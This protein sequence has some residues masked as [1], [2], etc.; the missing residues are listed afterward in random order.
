MLN[1][2]FMTYFTRHSTTTNS[3]HDYA[4]VQ[5][6]KAGY[7]GFRT[8]LMSTMTATSTS[9]VAPDESTASTVQST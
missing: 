7:K 5:L 2:S 8:A 6:T 9:S 3:V 1:K 4:P